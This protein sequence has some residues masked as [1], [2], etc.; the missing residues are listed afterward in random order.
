MATQRADLRERF[1]GEPEHVIRFFT[2]LAQ[3][4]REIMASLGVARFDDLVGH[5]Q[6]VEPDPDLDAGRA[7]ALDLH[8]LLS[9]PDET[10]VSPLRRHRERNDRPHDTHLDTQII[11]RLDLAELPDVSLALELPIANTDRAV[12]AQLSGAIVRAGCEDGLAD[13]SIRLTFRGTA[14]QSFGAFVTRGLRLDLIGEANDY[15]GKGLGGGVITIRPPDTAVFAPEDNV[16]MGNTVLYGATSGQLFAAGRAGE[17]FGVRNSGAQTVVEGVGDH[18][19]EYMTGGTVVVLGPTGKNFAAG[20]SAGTAYIYD[21]GEAFLKRF[22]PEL[23]SIARVAAPEAAE[24]LRGLIA[25]HV[26]ATGS[27]LGR[28]ILDAWTAEIGNFWQVTPNP[29]VVDTEAPPKADAA[30]AR[31]AV[32]SRRRAAL[33]HGG[34]RRATAPPA[35]S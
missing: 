32:E 12:G 3:G 10:H 9:P 35:S 25:D 29:P 23:V 13:E 4:V 7:A 5:V 1:A 16:I 24:E 26:E 22:N 17:R 34:R 11:N 30:R 15:V 8:D 19:C 31:R 2:H 27:A 21:R 28:R 14:G 20:M 18:G 33:R 6:Y